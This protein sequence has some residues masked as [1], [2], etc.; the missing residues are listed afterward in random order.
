MPDNPI[1]LPPPRLI[2]SGIAAWAKKNAPSSATDR[3]S[4]HSSRLI[5]RNGVWAV[6]QPGIADRDLDPAEFPDRFRHHRRDLVGLGDIGE[7]GQ[8]AAAAWCAD[9]ARGLLDNG[10]VAAAVDDDRRAVL[11]DR[12]AQSPC[13]SP[14]PA[15]VTIATLPDSARAPAIAASARSPGES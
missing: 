7:I 9:L 12:R 10:A 6:T 3:I 13:R 5:S 2:I 14:W 4:C 1:R 8:R 11:G 15:P